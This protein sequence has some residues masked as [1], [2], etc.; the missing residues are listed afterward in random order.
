M[1]LLDTAAAAAAET[2]PHWLDFFDNN[3][4]YWIT[5]LIIPIIASG[6]VKATF[7]K[8]NKAP[9]QGGRTAAQVAREILDENGLNHVQIIKTP[10]TLSDHYD[11]RTETVALSESVHDKN[12]IGAIAV[13][14]HEVGHAIQFAANYAPVKVRRA[15]FPLVRIG[16]MLW[17]YVF[18]AGIFLEMFGLI[19]VAIGLFSFVVLFQ[20]ITL[21]LEFD[22][23]RRAMKTV[24]NR[25]YLVGKEVAG[26]RKVL[27]AAA[28]TYIVALIAS[29]FQL[30]RLLAKARRR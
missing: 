4:L 22:A 30:L 29:V 17:V 25:N 1:I 14:A 15:V 28:F 2:A 20:F 23:S 3:L 19:W 18:L 24:T 6:M 10:G 5:G 12:T 13:A 27:T 8:Y 7:A 26:A 9:T 21:P 16:S 11:P